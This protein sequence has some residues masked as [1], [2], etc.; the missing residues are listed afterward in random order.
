ML[1]L[2]RARF[3]RDKVCGDGVAPHAVQILGQMGVTFE[4]F[5]GRAR[6]TFGG[7]ISG[8][9]GGWFSAQAPAPAGGA[10]AE[11]WVVPRSLLDAEIARC[12]QSAGAK[13]R[14]GV[15][16][17]GL[18][19]QRGQVAGVEAVADGRATC[20]A[21]KVV[22][23]A[24]GAHSAVARSVGYRENPPRHLG[25]AL[26]AYYD[27]VDG[28]RDELE[29]HCFNADMMPGYGWVF[30]TGPRSANVGVGFYLGELRRSGK[31]LRALLDDFVANAPVVN[32]RFRRARRVGRA[33]GW[34]LPVSSARRP[35]VFDG[36]LLCG[37]AA[38]LVDPLTGE[39]IWTA[40]VSGRSAARASLEAL[41]A[42]DASKRTLRAH[43]REWR[44]VS[45]GYLSAGRILKNFAKSAW[46]FDLM[47]KRA[48]QNPY[49]ASRAIGYGLG[50]LDRRRLLRRVLAQTL[51]APSFLWS[52]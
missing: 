7:A 5:D 20:F 8:P 37:D 36:V 3:P 9:S 17:T 31:K 6:K 29:I 41:R 50:I 46:F 1:V 28:L 34:P 32:A 38:S 30:P 42:G 12:A 35:T 47:V 27:E 24:D 18:A 4:S 25:Y 48:A 26:R 52:K 14:Q 43:E 15:E 39:G 45:G 2:E 51:L 11:S 22:I 10:R 21:A 23:G 33:A 40:L 19:Y 16:V 44:A 13:L 49:Y